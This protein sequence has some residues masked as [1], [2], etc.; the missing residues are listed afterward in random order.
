M[1]S[2]KTK[3]ILIKS[4][5]LSALLLLSIFLYVNYARAADATVEENNVM[6]QFHFPWS[7]SSG[8]SGLVKQIYLI[9]LGLVGALALGMIVFGGVQYAASAGNPSRQTDARDRITQAIWGVVLLLCAYLIFNT[10]N[11]DLLKL[12]EPNLSNPA[13]SNNGND[14]S[15]APGP[16]G[17]DYGWIPGTAS[18]GME[19][20]Q[21]Y[22]PTE[23]EGSNES[24]YPLNE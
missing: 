21:I 20:V 7:E 9:A 24:L 19:E 14:Y 5:A 10:I 3:K 22:T 17:S 8:I 1:I 13:N 15:W 23:E 4:A 6:K 2:K 16:E 12:K 11:P 18:S